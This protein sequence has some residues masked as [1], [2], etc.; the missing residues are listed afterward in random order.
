MLCLCERDTEL[1]AHLL[2]F[3]RLT[4]TTIKLSAA[5]ELVY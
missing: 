3:L 4:R 1:F 2:R 5:T